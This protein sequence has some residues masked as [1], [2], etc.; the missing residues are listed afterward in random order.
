MQGTRCVGTQ[1]PDCPLTIL[2]LLGQKRPSPHCG[3]DVLGA[4][5]GTAEDLVPHGLL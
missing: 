4:M 5:G 3:T 1:G 2:I